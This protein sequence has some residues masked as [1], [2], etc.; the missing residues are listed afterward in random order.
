MLLKFSILAVKFKNHK[1]IL[2]NKGTHKIKEI[3][4]DFNPERLDVHDSLYPAIVPVS[5]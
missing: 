3:Q 1:N 5:V 4:T 2:R